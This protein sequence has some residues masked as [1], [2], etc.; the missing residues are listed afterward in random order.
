[1][2]SGTTRSPKR[3]RRSA[4]SSTSSPRATGC[5]SPT[6][7]P[8]WLEL[9][10]PWGPDRLDSSR[11]VPIHGTGQHP[12]RSPSPPR[13]V[14]SPDPACRRRGSGRMSASPAPPSSRLRPSASGWESPAAAAASLAPRALGK[15]LP[16]RASGHARATIS[17]TCHSKPKLPESSAIHPEGVPCSD[18]ARRAARRAINPSLKRVDPGAATPGPAERLERRH[19]CAPQAYHRSGRLRAAGPV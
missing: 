19:S 9:L 4:T 3:P 10:E 1:M 14:V 13:P 11:E 17:S 18:Q 6:K 8:P 5:S 15:S 7:R 2:A 12:C 16:L